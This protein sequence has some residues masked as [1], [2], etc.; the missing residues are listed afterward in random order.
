M[1]VTNAVLQGLLLG[2]LYALFAAG[3]S[4]MFGVMRIVNLAHGA[5]FA[6]GAYLMVEIGRRLGFAPAFIISPVLVGLLGGVLLALWL[7]ACRAAG[8]E[9]RTALHGD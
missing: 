7:P 8:I 4:I 9:P 1:G 3:L 6:I 5:F 2:G